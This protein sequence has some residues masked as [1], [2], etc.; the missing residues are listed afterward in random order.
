MAP[1]LYRRLPNSDRGLR[2][3][4]Q[5]QSLVSGCEVDSIFPPEAVVQSQS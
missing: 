1:E 2:V 4:Q 3:L 5:V